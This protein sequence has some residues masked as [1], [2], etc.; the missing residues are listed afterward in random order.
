MTASAAGGVVD[1]EV[2]GRARARPRAS[3]A[4]V[5]VPALWTLAAGLAVALG[6]D[7][8]VTR[9]LLRL[10]VF[11]PK[12]DAAAAIVGPVA[13]AGAVAE[14][15]VAVLGFLLLGLL[16]VESL[17]RRGARVAT[18]PSPADPARGIGLTATLAVAAGGLGALVVPP[19]PTLLLG[20]GTTLAVA[21]LA[22]IPTAT[23]ARPRL[24]AAGLVLLAGS[25][26]AAGVGRAFEG[27]TMLIDGP[28]TSGS[29]VLVGRTPAAPTG[30]VGLAAVGLAVGLGGQIA[31]VVGA[32]ALGLAWLSSGRRPAGRN[33]WLLVGGL[34]AAVGLAVLVR[35]P[36]TTGLLLLWTLGLSGVVP[37]PVAIVALA[38][39][40]AGL[41]LRLTAASQRALGPAL[42]LLAGATPATSSLLLAS[43]LGLALAGPDTYDGDTG[44][45]SITRPPGGPPSTMAGP[46]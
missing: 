3:S 30:S 29:V 32:A 14:N 17:R 2:G 10:A 8:L 33:R 44:A 1:E 19:T 45:G 5:A 6:V 42:V 46:T 16:L 22:F 25:V 28:A 36:T 43:L 27:A 7:L 31:Y 24:E 26:A 41:G 18:P 11:V 21:A 23:M 13:R 20:F 9:F 39:V 37:P 35:A 38:V 34:V 15:L 12:S 4:R 40:V